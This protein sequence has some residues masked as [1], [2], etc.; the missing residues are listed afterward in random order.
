VTTFAGFDRIRIV[1]LPS[2]PDRRREMVGELRR[3]GLDHDP[4]V[5]F[6]D[7]VLVSDKAPFRA[8]GEKGVFL[9]HLNILS[10]AAAA[11]D[12]VLILEDDVDFTPAAKEWQLPPGI[13]IAY[14]GYEPSDPY[15]L[16]GSNIIGAHCMGFSARAVRA[17]VPFLQSLLEHESPPPI[18]GAYVWFRRQHR[19]FATQFAAPVVA[20]QRPSRSDIAPR[21]AFDRIPVLRGPISAARGVKRKVQRGEITFGLVEA[22]IVSLIGIAIGAAATWYYLSR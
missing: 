12:S 21:R 14:G 10:E 17:L 8:A 15:D 4:R 2:R 20:V 13:D 7:G 18:D 16:E 19:E 9:A 11:G 5:Q 6:A 1:N 22:I 3:V